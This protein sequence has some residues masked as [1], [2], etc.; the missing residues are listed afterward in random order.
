[1]CS[2]TAVASTGIV[3]RHPGNS[4]S[5]RIHATVAS[6]IAKASAAASSR[7]PRFRIAGT[8]RTASK[9]PASSS[10]AR[11][12][13][14]KNTAFGFTHCPATQAASDS[15]VAAASTGTSARGRQRATTSSSKGR[16]R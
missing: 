15:T 3:A 2:N 6:S 9:A 13:D 4:A 7:A 1:M 8:A 10:H 16:P 11:N 12:G 5:A 14:R